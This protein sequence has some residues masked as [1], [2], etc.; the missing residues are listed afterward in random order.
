MVRDSATTRRDANE[1][2]H[3]LIKRKLG[4]LSVRVTT[5]ENKQATLENKTSLLEHKKV[6]LKEEVETQRHKETT[7]LK[8]IAVKTNLTNLMR[9]ELVRLA[10][11]TNTLI[12]EASKNENEALYLRQELEGDFQQFHKTQDQLDYEMVEID[13]RMH[14][15]MNQVMTAVNFDAFAAAVALRQKLGKKDELVESQN[16]SDLKASS[17]AYSLRYPPKPPLP[18]LTEDDLN[19]FAQEVG[20][21][22][23]INAFLTQYKILESEVFHECVAA[24]KSIRMFWL[25]QFLLLYSRG[26]LACFYMP[27][28]LSLW[29]LLMEV[30][31]MAEWEEVMT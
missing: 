28:S 5:L 19:D 14:H 25:P 12:D 11:E 24:W 31:T 1:G 7:I 27:D 6:G 18:A 20:Y 3:R 30:C 15:K 4:K 10:A 9:E 23:D 22:K 8:E 26:M 13:D 21:P 17:A 16:E 2:E 29:G